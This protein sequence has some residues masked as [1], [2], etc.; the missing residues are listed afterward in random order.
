MKF[1]VEYFYIYRFINAVQRY[2][3]FYRID[4]G[5]VFRF[6]WF[7]FP[8]KYKSGKEKSSSNKSRFLFHSSATMPNCASRCLKIDTIRL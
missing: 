1:I 3:T 6:F 4:L 2:N 7:V 8:L 5:F